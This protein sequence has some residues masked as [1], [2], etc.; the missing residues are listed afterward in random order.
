MYF[1]FIP[2]SFQVFNLSVAGNN[3][4][5]QYDKEAFPRFQK[6]Q[7]RIKSIVNDVIGSIDKVAEHFK[8]TYNMDDP[9][10]VLCY[11]YLR[12]TID[13]NG[14]SGRKIFSELNDKLPFLIICVIQTEG[15]GR[16]T[17]GVCNFKGL[18]IEKCSKR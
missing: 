8:W 2:Y 13:L 10:I 3:D 1:N 16:L 14:K 9:Q 12:P 6:T 15:S 5:F 11:R 7:Q 18:F 17:F 4:I